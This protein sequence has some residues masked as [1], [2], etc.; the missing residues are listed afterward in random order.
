M[1]VGGGNEGR[2]EALLIPASA[3]DWVASVNR[4]QTRT[5]EVS[6]RDVITQSSQRLIHCPINPPP[7]T[8]V[9]A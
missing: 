1:K 5:P 9:L 7:V 3:Q 4:N 8:C 6:G 2:G